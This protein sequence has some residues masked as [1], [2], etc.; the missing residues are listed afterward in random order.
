MMV[1]MKE[2]EGRDVRIVNCV[3]VKRL[4]FRRA[5]GNEGGG[6]GVGGMAG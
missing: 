2:G 5:E 1:A 6:V 3:V 4:V